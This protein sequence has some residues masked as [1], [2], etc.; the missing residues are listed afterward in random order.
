MLLNSL[1]DGLNTFVFLS[2]PRDPISWVYT[3]STHWMC[4]QYRPVCWASWC[5]YPRRYTVLPYVHLRKIWGPA[6][7]EFPTVEK[8]E[9]V[10]TR[11]KMEKASYMH[12]LWLWG[13]PMSNRSVARSWAR[14][15]T[16]KI[17]SIPVHILKS[18]RDFC[19]WKWNVVSVGVKMGGFSN[20]ILL[21]PDSSARPPTTQ[22]KNKG[23]S[24][25]V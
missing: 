10:V 22:I 24:G 12:Q 14:W 13:G 19:G 25:Q 11:V 16:S 17:T 5:S 18:K 3:L 9:I 23:G 8:V 1:D 4:Q 6:A 7:T 2:G 21:V 20:S 15:L